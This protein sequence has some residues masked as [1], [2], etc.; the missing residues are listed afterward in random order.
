VAVHCGDGIRGEK[1][2]AFAASLGQAV[3]DVV[4][5]FLRAQG[6]QVITDNDPLGEL[7]EGG[8]LKPGP[9]PGLTH[10]DDLEK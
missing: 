2:L 10:Q 9:Q 6:S 7:G 1:G 3:L 5:C 4:S 8:L